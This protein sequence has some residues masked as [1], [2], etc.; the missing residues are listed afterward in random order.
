MR[1]DPW[2]IVEQTQEGTQGRSS[3]ISLI[4]PVALLQYI[5][6]SRNNVGDGGAHKI[7]RFEGLYRLATDNNQ[8]IKTNNFGYNIKI[9]GFFISLMTPQYFFIFSIY[10]LSHPLE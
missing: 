8:T 3:L 1:V 5:S 4:D 10:R 6:D 2:P 9:K 7:I